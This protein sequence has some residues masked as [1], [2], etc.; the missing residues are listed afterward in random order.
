MIYLFQLIPDITFEGVFH[1]AEDKKDTWTKQ[2]EYDH[3]S[4]LHNQTNETDVLNQKVLHV[5]SLHY[6]TCN[7][8]WFNS[9]RKNESFWEAKKEEY[10]RVKEKMWRGQ[11]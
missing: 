7:G 4:V 9:K 2:V 11:R 3:L 6:R 10:P 1:Y 5:I 8:T